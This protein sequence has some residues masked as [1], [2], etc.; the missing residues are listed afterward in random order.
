VTIPK[1]REVLAE[2]R[3]R[4]DYH[5]VV[6]HLVALAGRYAPDVAQTF[7]TELLTA[8]EAGLP[9]AES[10]GLAAA[11]RWLRRQRLDAA[12]LAPLLIEGDDGRER[13]RALRP[14]P[15]PAPAVRR[16]LRWGRRPDAPSAPPPPPEADL[17]EAV[18][19]LPPAEKR[20]LEALYGVGGAPRRG[21]R[22]RELRRLAERAVAR[23]RE[24]LLAEHFAANLF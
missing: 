8:R 1:L 7:F 9:E 11:R 24:V 6:E 12:R 22:S 10:V 21:R 4:E 3:V 15:R 20:A 16:Q 13:E 18:R 14:L 23:L 17:L 2:L 19:G 5:P